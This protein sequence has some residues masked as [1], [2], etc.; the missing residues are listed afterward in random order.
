M[1]LHDGKD[2]DQLQAVPQLIQFCLDAK[3]SEM[4]KEA[5]AKGF[6]FLDS[7]GCQDLVVTCIAN[8]LDQII[9][10]IFKKRL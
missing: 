10:Q 8:G 6:F 3:D 1:R 2:V 5:M 9:V 7:D 4:K